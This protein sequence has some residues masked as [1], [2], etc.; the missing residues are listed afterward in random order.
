[1]GG[2]PPGMKE[3]DTPPGMGGS[4]ASSESTA[5]PQEVQAPPGM[6]TVDAPPGM[7]GAS[8]TP[9]PQATP[10]DY[11]AQIKI[12]AGKHG[13]DTSVLRALGMQETGLGHGGGFNP[14][15]GTDTDPHNAGHGIFQL[16]PASGATGQDLARA[17]ADPEFAA[18]YAAKT[19][20]NNLRATHGDLRGALA[21]YNSGSPTS[22]V[23]LKYADQVMGRM[24]NLDPMQIPPEIK[25]K[26][27][28]HMGHV[29]AA[30]RS[31]NPMRA[32]SR[33]PETIAATH[34]E[35]NLKEQWSWAKHNGLEAIGDVL[36]APMRVV[37]DLATEANTHRTAK[38]TV[39][40]MSA[41]HDAL[42]SDPTRRQMWNNLNNTIWR[43]TPSLQK[44][45]QE[46]YR[47][48]F[49]HEM[50]AETHGRVPEVFH[51][52]HEVDQAIRKHIWAP[53][54]GVYQKIAP[55]LSSTA[56][57]VN[58][59]AQQVMADPVSLVGMGEH[60]TVA[61]GQMLGKHIPI[62]HLSGLAQKAL[63]GTGGVLRTIHNLMPPP[64][65]QAYAHLGNW[66]HAAE[67][68]GNK[69]FGVRRDLD[70]AGFTRDG[71]QMRMSIENK[72]LAQ[73]TENMN[74]VNKVAHDPEAAAELYFQ[75]GQTAANKKV[76]ERNVQEVADPTLSTEER[77]EMLK[78]LMDAKRDHGIRT[79][80]QRIFAGKD[81]LYGGTEKEL[82]K[83]SSEDPNKIKKWAEDS[84]E[85][86]KKLAGI[87]KKAI[88]W[89]SLPHGLINEGTL[90]YMA[91]GLPA[92]AEGLKAMIMPVKDEDIAF[93]RDHGALPTHLQEYT[94]QS[95]PV[96]QGFS[97]I[98]HFSQKTLEHMELGWRVGLMKTLNKTLGVPQT[99]EEK[100][101]RGYLI[102]NKI[103]DYR[104]QDAFTQLFKGLGGPFVAFH[105]GIVPRLFMQTLRDNPNR[106]LQYQ[107][108]GQ[109]IQQHQ[110]GAQ[111]NHLSD[112]SPIAEGATLLAGLASLA[113]LE[114]PAYVT[115]SLIFKDFV[116]PN[117]TESDKEGMVERYSKLAAHYFWPVQVGESLWSIAQG[118]ERPG[119]A[120]PTFAEKMFDTILME[121]GKHHLKNETGKQMVKDHR[122]INK[123][124]L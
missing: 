122:D 38:D 74:E 39:G 36:S 63:Q 78:K 76:L 50:S 81:H 29:A 103:G 83:L 92:V 116:D 4:S 104:N 64:V 119:E 95:N 55:G 42:T 40:V 71:K 107:R 1:M 113:K 19:M 101:L 20:Q 60:A 123:G 5:A 91:G 46:G 11:D 34:N 16:D 7:S 90:T 79:E 106:I 94:K 17:A 2:L 44:K 96:A 84:P 49:N 26:A 69:M 61:A 111:Q 35:N 47:Q 65:Q 41:I 28:Y 110:A 53:A 115:D 102:N 62:N 32:L 67:D 43:P 24:Q 120:K 77:K 9:Q 117:T 97:N 48:S 58:D 3:V 51:S 108:M 80:S 66:A 14:K 57:S 70:Q 56:Q 93:L 8:A 89:N 27:Q 86:F 33:M 73:H 23:G 22:Q 10:H 88:L 118:T 30:L 100:L 37:Q 6:Q 13:L 82:E 21:M 98:E 15:T 25:T 18:D 68:M 52:N 124:D 59:F 72:H 99:E 121:I 31:P 45:I 75:H 105:L 12:A 85:V 87:G 114:V 109:D 54:D 112:S